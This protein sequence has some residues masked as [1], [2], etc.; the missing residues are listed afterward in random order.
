MAK[1]RLAVLGVLLLAFGVEAQTHT[2]LT[3]DQSFTIANGRAL[4][5]T[6]ECNGASFIN[7]VPGSGGDVVGPAS[8][9]DNAIARFDLGTGKLLQNS[10]GIL[11]DAGALSGI[12]INANVIT[13]GT[14]ATANLGSGTANSSTFL[15][16]D[17]TW[18][19]PAGSG[20]VVGPGSA[21][22]NALSRFDGT[23]GKLVQNSVGIL[24]DAGTLTGIT[25]N[26]NV[27]T[28]GTVANARLASAGSDTQFQFNDGGAF[29]GA[30]GLIYNKTDHTTT[31]DNSTQTTSPLVVKDNGNTV[32]QVGNSNDSSVN[33]VEVTG[34]A[35]AAI[36]TLAFRGADTDVV[37]QI[38]AQ[39]TGG[40]LLLFGGSGG[41]GGIGLAAGSAGVDITNGYLIVG[42]PN[43]ADS[44][45]VGETAGRVT[46]E[47]STANA[48]ES[49]VGVTDPTVGDQTF[50][51]PDL[52][53]ATSD[54]VCTIAATQTLT[55]KSISAGQIN[56]G[57][58]ATARLGS[59][60]ANSSTFLRGD[61]TW[62]TPSGSGDFVG[63]GSATDNAVVRFDG[64]TGKLGQNSLLVV[65]DSGNVSGVVAA[66]VTGDATF[67][68]SVGAAN[69]VDISETA[70]RITFEG[71]TADAFETRLGVTDP[72]VGD[73]VILLPNL[74]GATT[75]T[76]VTL[77]ATQNITN[78]N[79]DLSTGSGGTLIALDSNFSLFDN[80]DITKHLAFQL[81]S[82]TTATTRTLTI[83]D[84]SGTIVLND[85]TA[86]L[87]NKTLTTPVI[88][89]ISNTGTVTLP[90]ST[91]TL[92]G[93]ATTDTLTNKTID[94]EG[95]GNVCTITAKVPL[96]AGGC[97]NATAYSFW[98]L[99]TSTPAAPACV[100]GTNIQ[101][102]VL[103]YADTS[104]GF[105]AQT[106][107]ILPADWTTTGGMDA[108]ILWTTTAT[109]GNAKW[110]L[111]TACTDIAATATDDPSFN[112]ADTAT[113]AA[114]GT[115]N[116]VQTSTI[117]GMTLTG[118]TT[119]TNMLLHLK[120]FR[121]GN[122]GSDTLAATARFVGIILTFRRAI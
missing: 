4:T 54:T 68:A 5:G 3:N 101:K 94:C 20:D 104:G 116:R 36:P 87:T 23:T 95:T 32:F 66:L 102:G 28:A 119:A 45:Y 109:T 64:T 44:V 41:S 1:F 78:K 96:M 83:P 34:A 37:G 47:G 39:G 69:A 10:V 80:G 82:I 107:L 49:R 67:G 40:V 79:I 9:T 100:T 92:V 63:P 65:D 88:S 13:S 97:N 75:D 60:T 22:D 16:G 58:M 108:K 29:G 19:T 111:S 89:S 12:T 25:V 11:S 31:V 91:D 43:A 7:C 57:T 30:P 117:T 24:S 114:P 99:P 33:Y 90:T 77:A 70:G 120:L 27:V 15:R 46:F 18:A 6:Y 53:A 14:V 76:V 103:D 121:D 74:A 2:V 50:L 110:S 56:S 85:N 93:K 55:N 115:A 62:A 86:T 52:A 38:T 118:C 17:Q 42:T 105:S 81:S 48:F 106:T 84:G 59:G 35:T 72:T 73:Q 98:D 122:D 113:T 71:V 61:S 8:S 51:F 21:T 26:G 112:T